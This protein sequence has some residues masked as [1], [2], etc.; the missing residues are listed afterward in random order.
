MNYGN[1]YFEQSNSLENV[2]VCIWIQRK[3]KTP[4]ICGKIKKQFKLNCEY[5]TD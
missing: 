3:K 1:A 4:K 2:N 5:K